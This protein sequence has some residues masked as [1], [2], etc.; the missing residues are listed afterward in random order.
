VR[1]PPLQMRAVL[2]AGVAIRLMVPLNASALHRSA[3]R[4]K[5]ND[6]GGAPAIAA[7]SPAGFPRI[8]VLHVSARETPKATLSI[9]LS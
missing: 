2:L 6:V 9:S 5:Q 8:A 4:A 1:L 7:T 3:P